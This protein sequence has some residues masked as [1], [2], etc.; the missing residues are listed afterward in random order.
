M[1][2][3]LSLLDPTLQDLVTFKLDTDSAGIHYLIWF[4]DREA[5]S[6]DSY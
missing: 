5:I 6:D 3:H 4:W 1:S 2:E